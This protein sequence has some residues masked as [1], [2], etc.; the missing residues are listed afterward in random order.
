MNTVLNAG[1]A[2]TLVVLDEVEKS[3][4]VHSSRG[5]RHTLTDA[6]LPLQERMTAQTWECPFFQ[7]KCDMS[8][9]NW[10]MTANSHQGLPAPLQSRCVVLDLPVLTPDQLRQFAE[11]E[12]AHRGLPEP[13]MAAVMDVF[14]CGALAN[15]GLSLRTISRMLD[16]AQTL[17][18]Q[19]ML[20]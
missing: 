8:W 2:G 1:H 14:D 6:L 13:A 16:R 12:G 9:I 17:A 5:S 19:P 20:N 10:V 15:A 7:I 4:D 11:M 3:G 18:C